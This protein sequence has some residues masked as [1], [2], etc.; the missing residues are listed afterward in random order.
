[1]TGAPPQHRG[2]L[3]G[4]KV[5]EAATYMTGPYATLLLADLGADVVKVEPPTG[6]TFRNFGRPPTY[7]S[8]P[9]AS[10]N[11]GKRS[12]V[13]DLKDPDGNA[14]LFELLADAD[15]FLTNWRAGVAEQLG[16]TDEA[17]DAVNPRL[18]RVLVTGFGP[19]GP[20]SA[21][22]AFDTAVQARSGLMDAL[23][24]TGVPVIL[25]G[26]PVDKLTALVA[27]QAVLA[28]LYQRERT[29]KGERID[30]AM[31]DVAA[32]LDFPDLFPNRVFLD[33]QPD[34]PHNKHL[35]TLRPLPAADGYVVIAPAA[36]RH[37]RAALEA[38]GHPEW[39]DE[40]LAIPGQVALIG[41]LFDRLSTVTPSDTVEHWLTRF[42]AHDVACAPCTTMDEHLADPQIAHNDVYRT[43]EWED[44]GTARYVRYPAVFRS[45]GH[46]VDE[47]P[48]PRL[49]ADTDD[50]VGG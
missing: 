13:L 11:R 6:D 8:A 5:V 1:V 21:E 30:V 17:L 4:V 27:T 24:P 12:V 28:A 48:P 18:I 36:G 50:I 15:V 10:M 35:F 26:Y 42:R 25:P 29:G 43:A 31:L 41:E 22:P 9:F 44:A 34:D 45:W 19:D 33:H 39:A 47:R 20:A 3:A 7:V 49:G 38:V 37:I 14:E 2:P 16:L 40:V 46:L 23:S 32:A